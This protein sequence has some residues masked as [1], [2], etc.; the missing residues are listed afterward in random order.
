MI[1]EEILVLGT[2]EAS[3]GGI[4]RSK[5]GRL[6]ELEKSWNQLIARHQIEKLQTSHKKKKIKR[7]IDFFLFF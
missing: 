5:D 1:K 7:F 3:H 2:S 4:V 6:A